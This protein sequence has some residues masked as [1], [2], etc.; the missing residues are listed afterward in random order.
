MLL[1]IS[2]GR[3]VGMAGVVIRTAVEDWLIQGQP[4]KGLYLIRTLERV[5]WVVLQLFCL[6][7]HSL[8][9]L[10][11]RFVKIVETTLLD[12]DVEILLKLLSCLR[13]L[14]FLGKRG[15][16]AGQTNLA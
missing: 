13:I 5:V 16:E 7:C 2:T 1:D 15:S 14:N 12:D 3:M 4:D 10:I 6:G 11:T 8:E 9:E